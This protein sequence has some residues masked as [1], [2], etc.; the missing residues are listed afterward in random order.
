[1]QDIKQ[2]QTVTPIL[3]LDKHPSLFKENEIKFALNAQV[4]GFNSD[5]YYITNSY[6][7][8]LCFEYT[9][10]YELKGYLKLDKDEYVLFFNF[11]AFGIIGILDTKTCKFTE[12]VRSKCLHFEND[13]KAVWKYI[14]ICESR[15]I[16]FVDG[17]SPDRYFDIDIDY[18]K[19]IKKRSTVPCVE[20]TYTDELDC[21]KLSFTKGL[22]YP[23]IDYKL[24][25]GTLLNGSYQAAIRYTD[26]KS[27][28]TESYIQSNIKLYNKNNSNG[29]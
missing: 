23:C 22:K 16:Y 19:K 24:S 15:R 7:N 3:N 29:L 17:K 13:V 18:P 2:I 20:D 21:D 25:S 6:S 26:N 14:S 28:I 1:M 11:G 9:F 4:E 5:G 27:V 8:E 12:K 10:G